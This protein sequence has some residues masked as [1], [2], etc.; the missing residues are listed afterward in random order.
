LTFFLVCS[1]WG[2]SASGGNKNPFSVPRSR[3]DQQADDLVALS[4]DKIIDL[5]RQEPGLLLVSKK[6]LVKKA[7]EQGRLLDPADLTDEALLRLTRTDYPIDVL[8][9]QE[10]VD[11]GYIRPKPGQEEIERQEAVR[12]ALGLQYIPP[13]P[14]PQVPGQPVRH[15]GNQE[16]AYWSKHEDDMQR[17]VPRSALAPASPSPNQN[18]PGASTPDAAQ[19]QR[20]LKSNS[21]PDY[22]NFPNMMPGGM[23]APGS[24]PSITPDQLPSLLST[25]ATEGGGPGAEDEQGG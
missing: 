11:R 23:G 10:I 5:L 8:I 18:I 7:F 15:S 13:A 17:Y 16:D 24:M 21:L 20:T 14:T 2:Q 1:G 4:P 9:T 19:L 6:L 25:S 3:A 22:G 12:A